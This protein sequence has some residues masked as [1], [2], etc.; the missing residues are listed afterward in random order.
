MS[1]RP[2]IK[3]ICN[4]I[5]SN[6]LY[7]T[8]ADVSIIN[9]DL[10]EQIKKNGKVINLGTTSSL[11]SASSDKIKTL[12]R[13]RLELDVLG[14]KV[15]NPIYVCENL[16][17]KAIMGVDLM[18]K[19]N[20]SFNFKKQEFHI[21]QISQGTKTDISPFLLVTKSS[22]MI[23]ALTALPLRLQG[24]NS[25]GQR[26]PLNCLAVA[27]I[28]NK[29]F[30]CLYAHEGLVKPNKLGEI[31]V[32]V[33]NCHPFDINLQ[34]NEEIGFLEFVDR[35]LIDKIDQDKFIDEISNVRNSNIKLSEK[36]KIDFL[37]TLNLSVPENERKAYEELFIKNHDVFSK[38]KNDLGRANNFEHNI[39][40]KAKD[41]SYIKQFRIPEAHRSHLE[42]QIKEWL[43]IGIIEPTHSRF[44]SPIFVVPKKD[45]TH[46]FVLNYRAL[47]DNSLDDRYTMKDVNECIGDIGRAG[48][49]I[50]S[51]MDLTSGFWQ[52]PLQHASRPYT[53]F[54]C[55]GMGQYQYKVLSMGLKGG[56]GSFQ[57]MVELTVKGLDR[58]IVYID[59]LLAHATNHSQHRA[60]LNELFQRLR[61][62]NLKLNP[63]KCEFGSKNVSYLGYRLT[64]E[65]IKPGKDKLEC[66]RNAKPPTSVKEVRA[67]LGLCN[68]FRSHIRNFAQ[69]SSPLCQLTTKACGWKGGPLPKPAYVSFKELQSALISEPIVAYPRKDRPYA[70]IVDASTGSDD[71]Q[72]GFGAI[73]C[74]QD[75]KNR[76]HVIAYA[77]RKL[78][79][80]EKNYTP[81]LAEMMAAV[82]GMNHLMST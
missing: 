52:L 80:H 62:V 73:L 79:K 36:E 10:F 63:A 44:N 9:K 23:P 15:K 41:P 1:K 38:N 51:T 56:P 67:F 40:L 20:L 16:N 59:D 8:G 43:K 22:E 60:D 35:N 48:S 47:N 46:R 74:Q 49:T 50:F 11:T 57:R 25:N 29:E 21:D 42:E 55:P 6:W 17:Q 82:W 37:K 66:V 27:Q 65:G 53:A 30:P 54:T 72:G 75:A 28:K 33:K 19:L 71:T 77:S 39:K 14:Q 5:A 78:A 32:W 26:P 76:F 2:S 4:G 3:V 61:A 45:G 34:R 69:I 12:G 81:F 24:E 70:L 18:K 68:F 64:P 13:V 7:D 58:I 31:T